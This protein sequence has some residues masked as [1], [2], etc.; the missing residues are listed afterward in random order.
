MRRPVSR[1]F[2]ASLEPLYSV[3]RGSGSR[4]LNYLAYKPLRCSFKRP[5]AR[6]PTSSAL[7]QWPATRSPVAIHTKPGKVQHIMTDATNH[8][9]SGL[10]QPTQLQK[11]HYGSGSVRKHLIDCLPG[12]DSK[13]F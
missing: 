3:A 8:P 2:L 7:I 5:Q 13:A 4:E 9:L 1:T 12:E 6:Q 10:W 11:L